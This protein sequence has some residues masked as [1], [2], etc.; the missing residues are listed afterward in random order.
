MAK[1]GNTWLYMYENRDDKAIYIGIGTSMGR[2]F[3]GHNP[4][5]ERLRD[6]DGTLIRQ[7]VRP[8]STREDALQAEAVAI[9]VACLAGFDTYISD[10]EYADIIGEEERSAADSEHQGDQ[11]RVTNISSTK[12]TKYLT[13]AIFRRP[14]EVHPSD[15]ANTIIVPISPDAVVGMPSAFGGLSGEDFAPRA[16]R[17]WNVGRPKRPHIKHLLAVLKGER[18][19]ILGSWEVAPN[20]PWRLRPDH[21]T[22]ESPYSSRVSIPIVSA[23]DDNFRD[24]KGKTYTGR[25]N[26]G[27]TYS[28]DIPR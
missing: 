13:P 25:L 28:P 12:S 11:L 2:V 16:V 22:L 10:T 20:H 7:T 1:E 18:R 6:K 27:V 21:A 3:E 4:A 15:L 8:F 9:H 24:M 19:V 17:Y 5:A 26:S 14:G 23:K